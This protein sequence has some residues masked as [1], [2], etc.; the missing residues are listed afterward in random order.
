MSDVKTIKIKKRYE[1][2][3]SLD[4][5]AGKYDHILLSSEIETEIECSTQ[6]E[7][8]KKLDSITKLVISE[9]EK[10]IKETI[11]NIVKMKKD[12]TNSS[13]IGI[14]GKMLNGEKI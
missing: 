2:R 14:G 11:T 12:K 9:T 10:D 6:D 3:V 5:I 8:K 1:R 4:G 13:L 7:M